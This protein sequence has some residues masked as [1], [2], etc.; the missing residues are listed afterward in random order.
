MEN[1]QVQITNNVITPSEDIMG[2]QGFLN[3]RESKKTMSFMATVDDNGKW[4]H[5]SVSYYGENKK[6]PSWAE[7]CAVKNIFWGPDE[8]VHQ[9]H[10]KESEYVHGF[11]GKDNILHLWRPVGGWESEG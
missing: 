8:E 3:L 11:R 7:M 5:V 2:I 4:E 10:P 6:T 9:I 1:S